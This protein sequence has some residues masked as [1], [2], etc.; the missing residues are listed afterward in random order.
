MKKT[1]ILLALLTILFSSCIDK[2]LG[3]QY[4]ATIDNARIMLEKSY[5]KDGLL[6]HFPTSISN[7]SFI[8]I[9]FTIPDTTYSSD[10]YYTGYV[11]LVLKMGEDSLSLYPKSYIYKTQYNSRN[12]I[13]DDSF[14][15]YKYYDTLKLRN[16]DIAGAY[17]I[18][19]F[20]DF[21]FGLGS[22]RFDLRPLGMLMV[23]DKYYVPDDLEVFVL[24][25]EH[26][27]FWKK[28]FD[29]ERPNTLGIWKNGYSCGI[30]ISRKSNM[31]IYWMKAW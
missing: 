13:L 23:I 24:K 9:M 18:P 6:E 11:Y 12:F 29:L 27:Y 2:I 25:A 31:I 4:V 20:I 17:P 7:K 21:D 15:Y 8:D 22:E 10:D 28:K 30:A 3:H 14:K 1:T 26:G 19:Y 5:A 16:V